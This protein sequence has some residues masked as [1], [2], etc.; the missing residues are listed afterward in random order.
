MARIISGQ[1]DPALTRIFSGPGSVEFGGG[2]L[3]H[4]ISLVLLMPAAPLLTPGRDG[5]R[6]WIKLLAKGMIENSTI[7]LKHDRLTAFLNAFA[8]G[9]THCETPHAANLLIVDAHD[10]GCPTHLLFR[11]RAGAVLPVGVRLCAAAMVDFGGSANPLLGALPDEIRIAL[12]DEPPLLGLAELIAA[13]VETARCGGGSVQARL[14]EVVVVLAIRRAIAVGTVDGGLLAGLAHPTLY[15]SLIAM[16]DN[17]ARQWQVAE[18]ARISGMSR[19]Q[20]TLV[21]KQIL[22]QSP[23]AYLNGWRLVL[24]RAKLRAGH[25]VKSVAAMVGFGSA[26][27]FSRAFSRKFGHAPSQISPAAP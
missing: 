8:L 26:A 3:C 14:C 4:A 17:P 23:M 25:S 16:H 11:A 27:A 21:F 18:L 19:G 13:E 22:C 5:I 9:T 24:G 12:A 20:F 15:L 2:I 6:F 7:Q 10:A 1:T